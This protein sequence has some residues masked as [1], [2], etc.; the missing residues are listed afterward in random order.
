MS[1]LDPSHQLILDRTRDLLA[2]IAV[3]LPTNLTSQ[4]EFYAAVM[5]SSF[6]RASAGIPEIK[7]DKALFSQAIVAGLSAGMTQV[8]EQTLKSICG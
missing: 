6:A 7:A 2:F 3:R 4:K 8:R 1:V 5:L